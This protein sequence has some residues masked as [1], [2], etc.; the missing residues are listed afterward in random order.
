MT[1]AEPGAFSVWFFT[2]SHEASK[3]ARHFKEKHQT[4]LDWEA[5]FLT[6]SEFADF[7]CPVYV[8]KQGV[9]D[10]VLV[11]RRSCHQVTNFGGLNIK[12]SWSRMTPLSLREAITEECPIYRRLST[13]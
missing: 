12:T 13:F 11:P 9:G 10:L 1:Y 4:E 3:V 7:P 6:P 2:P 8:C 5:T